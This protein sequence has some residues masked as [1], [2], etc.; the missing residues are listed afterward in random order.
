[1]IDWLF[2]Y[3][4]RIGLLLLTLGLVAAWATAVVR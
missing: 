1:M 3:R 4:D 2:I